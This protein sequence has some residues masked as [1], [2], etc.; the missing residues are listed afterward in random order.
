MTSKPRFS[1][2]ARL[3]S[4]RYAFDGLKTLLLEQHNARIHLL[5]SIAVLC[6]AGLLDLATEQWLW[7]V[8]AMVLVW[9][10]EAVNTALE[11]L[12]DA[13]VPEQHPLIKKANDVAAAAVLITAV[14]ASIIGALVLLPA[15]IEAL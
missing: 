9:A 5:A 10:A 2:R 14:G 11:Y 6:L 8:L 3:A 1:V 7:L 13:A 15:M 12:A 4:F